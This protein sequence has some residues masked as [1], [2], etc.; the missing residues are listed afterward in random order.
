LCIAPAALSKARAGKFSAEFDDEE[1]EEED[2]YGAIDE[3]E[4]DLAQEL[5]PPVAKYQS[6]SHH[7]KSPLD[8]VSV[9]SGTGED[10][11]SVYLDED[12][13]PI[14]IAP[15][16]EHEHPLRKKNEVLGI[17]DMLGSMSLGSKN[18]PENEVE[19]KSE[20]NY[21]TT[22]KKESTGPASTRKLVEVPYGPIDGGSTLT[23]L[24]PRKASKKEQQGLFKNLFFYT[25]LI[26]I[27]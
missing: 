7:E 5:T 2:E 17:V 25:Q 23:V 14:A 4:R 9:P 26:I 18:I 27:K 3:E 15:A 1:E 22:I 12:R 13:A 19:I 6:L 8:F 10:E 16:D 21:S 11:D 24:T 20:F